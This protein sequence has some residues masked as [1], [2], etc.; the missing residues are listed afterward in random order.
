[1][2][3]QVYTHCLG[4]ALTLNE[5]THHIPSSEPSVFLSDVHRTELRCTGRH[6]ALYRGTDRGVHRSRNRTG[7]LPQ[8]VYSHPPK[9]PIVCCKPTARNGSVNLPRG[10][11]KHPRKPI[12]YATDGFFLE[13]VTYI[14][15]LLGVVAKRGKMACPKGVFPTQKRLLYQTTKQK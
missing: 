2:R 4:E 15:S 5:L 7:R 13:K 8:K 1:M 6:A 12:S 10:R 9:A 14:C 3:K 11:I